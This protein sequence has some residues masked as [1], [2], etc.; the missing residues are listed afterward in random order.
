MASCRGSATWTI[1]KFQGPIRNHEAASRH[2]PDAAV[3]RHTAMRITFFHLQRQRC[4]Q[5]SLNAASTVTPGV[6]GG[7]GSH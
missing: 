6:Q 2:H 4:T 1:L 3:I 7:T 5:A